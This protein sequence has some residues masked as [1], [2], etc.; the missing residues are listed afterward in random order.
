MKT[1]G[2]IFPITVLMSVYNGER[3]LQESIKSILCQTFTNFEFI[4]IDDCS[5]D[6]SCKII[7][8]Y[9]DKRIKLIRNRINLGLSASLNIG[10]RA[11]RG[12]YIARFDSDDI[13]CPERIETQYRF[14]E[15]NSQIGI[16]GT[17][18]YKI[19]QNGEGK[20]SCKE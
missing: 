17:G 3:Y 16:L 11:S 1:S 4:I 13:S 6:T 9:N 20:D 7:E 14:M 18:Y 5:D 10:I 2:E 8:S 15:E 12:K 19:D